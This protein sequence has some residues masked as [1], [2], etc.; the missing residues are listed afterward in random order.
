MYTR[1]RTPTH[2]NT[3]PHSFTHTKRRR[4]LPLGC[5]CSVRN[6]FTA[7]ALLSGS[8]SFQC[9]DL[10]TGQRSAGRLAT[11]DLDSRGFLGV[12]P[13][14]RLVFLQHM[15]QKDVSSKRSTSSRSATVFNSSGHLC[16]LPPMLAS[17]RGSTDST[18]TTA[19]TSSSHRRQPTPMLSSRGEGPARRAPLHA[20]AAVTHS[21]QR[22]CFAS[23]EKH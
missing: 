13:R 2:A 9:Y 15:V 7:V 12:L 4:F 17:P 10:P 3:L 18:S 19:S 16:Q 22:R 1:T 21:K 23:E 11:L 6:I 14:V 8:V 5:L 20:P